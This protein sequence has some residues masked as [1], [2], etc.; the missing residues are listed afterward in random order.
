[1]AGGQVAPFV[2]FGPSHRLVLELI[3][4]VPLVLAMLVRLTKSRA[5]I[6][7]LLQTA[8]PETTLEMSETRDR[9]SKRSR[10]PGTNRRTC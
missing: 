10:V 3:V 4:L 6:A 1:M 2:V 5:A 7:Q 9:G 8:N